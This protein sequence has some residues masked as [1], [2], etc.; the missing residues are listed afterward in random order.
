MS[1]SLSV[2]PNFEVGFYLLSYIQV[3]WPTYITIPITSFPYIDIL[4]HKVLLR[5]K[6]KC[7]HFTG[8][9]NW[10][11]NWLSSLEGYSAITYQSSLYKS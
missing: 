3:S 7:Y 1:I 10:P 11:L 4:A 2:R 8:V 6:E 9:V 5:P